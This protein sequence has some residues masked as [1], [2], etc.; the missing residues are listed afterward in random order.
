MIGWLIY[1]LFVWLINKTHTI[2]WLPWRKERF[3]EPVGDQ[4][5]LYEQYFFFLR[6]GLLIQ[7]LGNMC[8]LD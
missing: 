6:K 7:K 4:F 8:K 1:W 2:S 3:C 5:T